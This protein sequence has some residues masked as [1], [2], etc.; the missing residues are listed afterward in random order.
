VARILVLGGGFCG[1][2]AGLLLVRDAHEIIVLERDGD[3]V[4][5]SADEAWEQWSRE[6]VTQFRQAH[7]LAA[8]GR[9][10]LQETLPDVLDGLRAAGACR[11]DPIES[12]R[13]I[14]VGSIHCHRVGARIPTER[15]IFV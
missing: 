13:S 1:L 2:A 10:V 9:T 6:G 11:F 3:P 5:V 12:L 14:P 4:P 7:F 8:G 15:R